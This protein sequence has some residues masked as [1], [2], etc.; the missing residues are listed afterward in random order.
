MKIVLLTRG[1]AAATASDR[2][3]AQYQGYDVD[4]VIAAR[5]KLQLLTIMTPDNIAKIL[6]ESWVE[7]ICDECGSSVEKV[8]MFKDMNVC[9]KCLEGGIKCVTV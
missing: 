9:T 7:I 2:W 4:W 6:G 3:L 5:N 8:A 1:M